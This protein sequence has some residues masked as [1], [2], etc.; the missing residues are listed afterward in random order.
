MVESKVTLGSIIG[1]LMLG[2][3]IM[4]ILG[5]VAV[6]MGTFNPIL[7]Q[8]TASQQYITSIFGKQGL[9]NYTNTSINT[10]FLPFVKQSGNQATGAVGNLAVTSGWAFIFGGIGLFFNALANFPKFIYIMTIETFQ[11]PGLSRFLPFDL[12]GLLSICIISYLS[13]ILVFKL[14]SIFSKINVEN[15]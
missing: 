6:G 4:G 3:M 8:S 1:T 14:I 9:Q 5:P 11:Y 15:T 10:Y 7:N 12:A 2:I 13:I